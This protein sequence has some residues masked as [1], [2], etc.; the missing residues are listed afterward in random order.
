[1]IIAHGNDGKKRTYK[2]ITSKEL[3]QALSHA[4]V[5]ELEENQ[6]YSIKDSLLFPSHTILQGGAILKLVKGLSKWGYPKCSILEEKAMLMSRNASV[7]DIKLSGITIDGSQADYYPDVKLGTSQFNMCNFIGV[8][9]LTIEDCTFKNGCNDAVLLHDCSNVLIDGITVNKCGHDGI[10]CYDCSNISVYNS[11]FINR[12][13]SSC[14]FYNVDKGE[15]SYNSCVTS[16]GGYT[17]LQLQGSLKDITI[18]GNKIRGL[19]Y[20][21]IIGLNTK[22]SNV[23]IKENIIEKCKSPGISVQG[24]ILKNNVI[25]T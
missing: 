11:V 8:S 16:G 18:E 7:K 13:N 2:G 10:Y 9:G 1:M 23:L 24:A 25:K 19:P 3:N 15:F 14:R 21:G 5:V 17:G 12:T 22:M 4:G 20:P 6:I